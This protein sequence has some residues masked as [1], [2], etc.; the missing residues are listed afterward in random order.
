MSRLFQVLL[1][2]AMLGG[3][4]FIG[5][6]WRPTA[7]A[8]A[9]TTRATWNCV[10]LE[11]F[12]GAT[13]PGTTRIREGTFITNLGSKAAHVTIT[14]YAF[15]GSILGAD[16]RSRGFDDLR[17]TLTGTGRGLLT[18]AECDVLGSLAD[19]FPLLG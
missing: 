1:A 14:R 12:N 17:F 13:E 19:R 10:G 16:L 4:I 5:S 8:A 3:G 15:N 18:V 9:P 2:A 7:E 11:T 6:V